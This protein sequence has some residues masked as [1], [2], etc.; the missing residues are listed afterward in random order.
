[1]LLPVDLDGV[2][3]NLIQFIFEQLLDGLSRFLLRLFFLIIAFNI[4]IHASGREKR[5]DVARYHFIEILD[6]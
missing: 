6:I 3:Y 1:M 2:T 4:N 5:I